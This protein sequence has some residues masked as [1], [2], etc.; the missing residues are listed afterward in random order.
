METF[1]AIL[2]IA[3][4]IGITIVIVNQRF[5]I[6]SLQ[7]EIK[8]LRA[9]LEGEK[10][11]SLLYDIVLHESPFH[12]TNIY[13]KYRKLDDPNWENFI[14]EVKRSIKPKILEERNMRWL[15]GLLFNYAKFFDQT[16]VEIKKRLYE[17]FKEKDCRRHID[18]ILPEWNEATPA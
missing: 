7:K 17:V 16:D 2:V 5:R 4:I 1:I 18:A 6:L 11:G 13:E 3:A 8:N 12:L 15:R 14:T 9:E 10:Q